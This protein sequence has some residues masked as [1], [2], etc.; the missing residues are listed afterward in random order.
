VNVDSPPALGH[1]KRVRHAASRPNRRLAGLA[2]LIVEAQLTARG[3]GALLNAERGE[4]Q[5]APNA[6]AAVIVL[7]VWRRLPSDSA[8]LRLSR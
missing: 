3:P 4:V 7:A 1:R 5:T 8:D 6:E 2:V